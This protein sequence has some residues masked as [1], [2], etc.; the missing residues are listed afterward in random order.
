MIA[1]VLPGMLK[2]TFSIWKI[3]LF[4]GLLAFSLLFW[5]NDHIG[6]QAKSA[7]LFTGHNNNQD[8]ILAQ[9]VAS[10][11]DTNTFVERTL[12]STRL[13]D[14]SVGQMTAEDQQALIEG[15]TVRGGNQGGLVVVVSTDP[16]AETAE[17]ASVE[18][19]ETLLRMSRLYLGNEQ[20]F[21]ST[22]IDEAI[23]KKS[24]TEPFLYVLKSIALAVVL[25]AILILF[26]PAFLWIRKQLR[27]LSTKKGESKEYDE[28]EEHLEELDQRFVPQKLDPTFLY[29]E[30]ELSTEENSAAPLKASEI[31]KNEVYGHPQ[32]SNNTTPLQSVSVSMEDLPFSFET[33]VEEVMPE[34]ESVAS[35]AASAEAPVLPA[36][37]EPSV[38]EYKKRLNEL[39]AQK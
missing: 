29:P 17:I 20:E 26:M 7:I 36:E 4:G 28:A 39:L 13:Q 31:L 18:S 2:K 32:E 35:Q 3:A 5:L 15:V 27:K 16:D 12:G 6:Y 8:D 1:I 33:P 14:G 9:T 22:V 25:F 10:L 19:T 34:K 23:I 24:L 30:R 37:Q 21:T 38:L 11:A